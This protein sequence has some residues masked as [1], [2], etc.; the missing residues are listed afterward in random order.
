MS[1]SCGH[2]R[3]AWLR[4]ETCLHD[5]PRPRLRAIDHSL[6][7]AQIY[8]LVDLTGSGTADYSINVVDSIR[9]GRRTAD[10]AGAGGG[11]PAGRAYMLLAQL[12]SVL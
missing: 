12:L 8:A 10:A 3:R 6:R 5:G 4:M 2:P 1:V 9:W 7:S 11:P